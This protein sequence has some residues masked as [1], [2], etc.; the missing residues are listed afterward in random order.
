M[1]RSTSCALTSTPRTLFSPVTAA[2]L[3]A[4]AAARP[5]ALS[6][7]PLPLEGLEIEDD[8]PHFVDLLLAAGGG[9]FGDVGLHSQLAEST[10]R[11][12]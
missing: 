11:R 10:T 1:F 5:S 2:S 9:A 3:N 7:L 12:R 8:R 6:E 4:V